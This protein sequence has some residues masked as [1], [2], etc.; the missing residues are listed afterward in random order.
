MRTWRWISLFVLGLFVAG[1]GS[2]WI[3]SPGYMDADYYFATGQELARGHGFIEPFL[4]NYLDDPTGLPHP[5]HLYWLPLTSLIAALP[6]ALLGQAFRVA[7]IPFI[8]MSASLPLVTAALALQVHGNRSWAWFSGLLALVPG[9]Y[10]PYLLTTDVFI[11]YALIGAGFFYF[12]GQGLR[13]GKNSAWLISG[14]MIGLA[15]FARADGLLFFLPALAAVSYSEERKL[16]RFVLMFSGYLFVM[17]PWFLRNYLIVGS[18]LSSTGVKTLW[19][20]SYPE[21]FSYPSSILTLQH[22]LSQGLSAILQ[23]RF[24]ALWI[25]LQRL[26]GEN[27]LVILGP[28]MIIGFRELW[29]AFETRLA[30]IYLVV[31]FLTMS[32]VFPFAGSL[33]GLFHSSAALMPLLW[34]LVPAGLNRAIQWLSH[35]RRWEEV[36]AQRV[37]AATVLGMAA[38]LTV[39]I[40]VTK[41]IGIQTNT[42]LWMGPKR[43]YDAAAATLSNFDSDDSIV[44]V[45]N[46]PGFY[47]S[48]QRG[49]VVIPNGGEAV[50][51]QVIDR[52]AVEWV[53]LDVNHPEGLADLYHGKINVPWLEERTTL[54]DHNNEPVLIFEVQ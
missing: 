53:I 50:L 32:F 1:L 36:R 30:A 23:A 48:S 49:S 28:F 10:F 14:M 29:Q 7:Q 24:G 5:S 43:T 25:N 47:L 8:I 15:H 12:A 2:I 13:K 3:Q 16:Q 35:R 42:L 22:F 31:L 27:G 34:V 6:M 9:F 19:L 52:F 51:H 45:N 21:L 46:P 11:V 33:G 26:L 41:V 39:G 20:R 44:A 4:W 17:A 37:F 18:L 38:M 40:F 54:L